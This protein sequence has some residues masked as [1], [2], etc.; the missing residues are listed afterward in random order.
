MLGCKG[1]VGKVRMILS[2]IKYYIYTS[3]IWVIALQSIMT[4]PISLPIHPVLWNW[5]QLFGGRIRMQ[6]LYIDAKHIFLILPNPHSLYLSPLVPHHRFS[7]HVCRYKI[8][9][10]CIQH[11]HPIQ[12]NLNVLFSELLIRHAPTRQPLYTFRFLLRYNAL[13]IIMA[14]IP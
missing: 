9:R 12:T 13:V 10:I 5:W 8:Y 11:T 4:Y 3:Y 14:H 2:C 6:Y 1:Y 7:M